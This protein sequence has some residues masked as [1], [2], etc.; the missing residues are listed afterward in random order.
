MNGICEFRRSSAMKYSAKSH[1]E[2]AQNSKRLCPMFEGIYFPC[3]TTGQRAAR[4]DAKSS[5]DNR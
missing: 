1:G 5:G 2:A 3:L 4:L